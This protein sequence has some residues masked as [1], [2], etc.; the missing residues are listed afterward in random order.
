MII[1][2]VRQ[3]TPDE[4]SRQIKSLPGIYKQFESF[5]LKWLFVSVVLLFPF[6]LLGHYFPIAS[7]IQAV[8]CIVCVLLSVC[9]VTVWT[10]RYKGGLGN[11]KQVVAM[12]TA[13]VEIVKVKTNRA[14][15]REDP[16]DYGI[17]FYLDVLENGQQKTLYLWGQYLDDLEYENQFPN[18][19]F[20]FIRKPGSDEFIDF[21][22]SGQY[23]N[24]ERTLPPFEKAVWKSGNYP[25][26]GQV[27]EQTLD[28]IN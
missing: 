22:V 15:K 16:E 26:N 23:F 14:I 28:S 18:T 4:I 5:L 9:I 7:R 3:P 19:E 10:K 12:N 8:Y 21:K 17:A 6:L 20:E 24:P 13:P 25:V 1:S 2:T 27:L 11:R